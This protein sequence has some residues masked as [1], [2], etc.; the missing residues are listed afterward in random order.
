RN[1]LVWLMQ[2]ALYT[3]GFS[4]IPDGSFGP[5][6]DGQVRAFQ[7]ARGLGIDGLAGPNTFERLFRW[8]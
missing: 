1:N 5:I 3:N 2:A 6:T 4:T 7:R 8:E